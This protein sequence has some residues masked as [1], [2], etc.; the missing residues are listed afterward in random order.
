MT[1][2]TQFYTMLAMAG[3]GGW[4]GAAL[5]TYG[6]FL[7]RPARARWFVF[8]NDIVFWVLQG[9]CFFYVLL[10]V[11]EGELRVYIFLAVLCG[12]AFYQGALKGIYL[13]VLDILIKTVLWVCRLL[14]KTANYLLIK[15][16]TGLFHLL[17]VLLT[18]I[19]NII[20]KLLKGASQL[21]WFFVKILLAP[22]RVLLR[23]LW[24]LVPSRLRN[25]I[26]K[27]FASFGG[28]SGRIK[29]IV[30]KAAKWGKR[31]FRK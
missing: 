24:N 5:D 29:N 3:M 22:F 7:N 12:Y 26:K 8:L 18:G 10:L 2:S 15:P 30:D 4:L 25:L 14:L 27:F 20:W 19:L 21:L 13:K 11:N 17:I 6:R 23:L 28:F 16:V 9:L 1:L 31:I